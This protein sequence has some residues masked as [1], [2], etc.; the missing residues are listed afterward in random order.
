MSILGRDHVVRV[1]ARARVATLLLGVLAVAS[2]L[3]LSLAAA[4]TSPGGA[5]C[6][7]P[8]EVQGGAARGTGEVREP[9]LN[10]PEEVPAALQ[11]HGGRDFR[12]TVPTYVHVVSPDGVE[13]MVPMTKVREQIR[14]LAQGF[15]GAYGGADTGFRFDLVSVDYSVNADWYYAGP[16]SKGERDM[17][18][19]L[20]E[21]GPESMNIY[22]TTAGIYLGWSYFPSIW[23]SPGQ[24]YLDGI[25][26]DW[27]SLPGMGYYPEFDLGFTAVHEAGHW[28]NLYHT[29]QGG[30]NRW[31]DYVDDTP[32]QR[33]PSFGCPIGKDTCADPGLDPIHNFM[34]YSD[35]PCYTEFTTGQAARM[36]DAWLFWRA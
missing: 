5:A 21:G 3:P 20:H 27:K 11:G 10:A 35:D 30:C 13:A 26:V 8:S 2:M 7:D 32:P 4:P 29:F 25:V 17:K 6:F 9:E 14:V 1:S 23:Q 33:T 18:H 22:L 24:A 31:G 36:Q 19:A 16:S 34:D 28:L 15:G 12:A